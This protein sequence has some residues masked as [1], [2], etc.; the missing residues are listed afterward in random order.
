MPSELSRIVC[1][2]PAMGPLGARMPCLQALTPR[3]VSPTRQTRPNDCGRNGA[4]RFTPSPPSN[5]PVISPCVWARTGART[6][7]RW[8][9]GRRPSALT[10]TRWRLAGGVR[11]V[12]TPAVTI[13]RIL[14][15]CRLADR[16]RHAALGVPRAIARAS[17]AARR[18]RRGA[19][20]QADRKPAP[21]RRA[22]VGAP[23]GKSA[24]AP[25]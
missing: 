15:T 10:K 4:A 2:A 9:N 23:T 13:G 22:G 6:H 3:A 17:L 11:S 19:R 5:T 1:S 21:E 7:R 18:L 25:P 14:L 16:D 8:S 24:D 12:L 20:R